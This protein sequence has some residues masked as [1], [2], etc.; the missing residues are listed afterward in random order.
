MGSYE[1]IEKS[2]ILKA[3]DDRLVILHG[4]WMELGLDQ[5][6]Q[7][8][9]NKTIHNLLIELLDTMVEEEINAKEELLNRLEV[10]TKIAVSLSRD[11][12]VDYQ[13]PDNQLVLVKYEQAVRDEAVR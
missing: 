10:N 3:V 5:T 1:N 6:T 9:K 2:S 12:E 7:L 8:D 13:E 11:L 4:V